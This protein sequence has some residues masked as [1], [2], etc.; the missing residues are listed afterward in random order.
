MPNILS[1]L[2]IL[3]CILASH[4]ACSGQIPHKAAYVEGE[5]V[6]GFQENVSRIEAESLHQ[7]LG[8]TMLKHFEAMNLDLVRIKEG[9]AVEEAITAYLAEPIVRYAE[10][11]YIRRVQPH[12]D[13]EIP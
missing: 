3:L 6:V 1:Y 4:N 13:G 2:F 7:R 10:P 9:W 8:S 5:I 11:N 12:G